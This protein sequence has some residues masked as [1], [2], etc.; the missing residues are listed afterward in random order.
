M[1]QKVRVRSLAQQRG[2][3]AFASMGDKNYK[4]V[5]YSPRFFQPGG[6]IPGSTHNNDHLKT[7][8]G[9]AVDFYS[10]LKLDGPLNPESKTFV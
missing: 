10:G 7:Q 8:C 9:K 3:L 1:T 5:E 4:A 6:L 2:N